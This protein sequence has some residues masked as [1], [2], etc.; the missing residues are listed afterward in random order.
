MRSVFLALL[1]AIGV[2]AQSRFANFPSAAHS[3]SPDGQFSLSSQCTRQSCGPS[4]RRLWLTDNQNHTRKVLLEVERDV[5][6]GWSPSGHNFFLNDNLGSNVAEAYLYFPPDDR[7]LDLLEAIDQAYPGDNRLAQDS[8]HYLNALYWLDGN[9]VLVK[10]FGHFDKE[11]A[12]GFTVC[13]RVSTS[14]KVKRV[15]E[16]ARENDPCENGSAAR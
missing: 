1:V 10:R 16:T 14:G 12:I 7:R 8:H 15:L 5:R 13:Y 9:T 11:G 6:I 3:T 4:D 2:Q